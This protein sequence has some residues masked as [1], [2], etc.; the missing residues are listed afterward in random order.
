MITMVS[1]AILIPTVGGM[2]RTTSHAYCLRGAEVVILR[3]RGGGL[4]TSAKNSRRRQAKAQLQHG[5]GK[6][7]W[8]KNEPPK[9]QRDKRSEKIMEQIR[10]KASALG[11]NEKVG[12]PARSNGGGRWLI[13]AFLAHTH[14]NFPC[15]WFAEAH[16]SH[17]LEGQKQ[18]RVSAWH[19]HARISPTRISST[20]HELLLCVCGCR[21]LSMRQAKG[22]VER[23]WQR[24]R[25]GKSWT[26]S[27]RRL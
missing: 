24:K 3:L 18:H 11:V 22:L 12:P 1:L 21:L 8:R 6:A 16:F 4:S 13:A 9:S 2:D 20:C 14:T 7:S 17:S 27:K 10:E 5:I 25:R 23:Q 19:S 26:R 15:W